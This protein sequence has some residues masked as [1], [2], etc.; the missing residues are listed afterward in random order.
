MERRRDLLMAVLALGT[1]AMDA[2]C[3][4]GVGG[5][6]T[7]V[8]TGNM[9]LLGIGAGDRNGALALRSGF[10]LVGYI[11]GTAAGSRLARRTGGAA[12]VWPRH[13]TLALGF[14]MAVMV[15]FAIWFE[16]ADGRPTGGTQVSLMVL[17]AL[18]MGVQSAAIRE[19]R[20]HDLSTTYLTGT[21]TAMVGDLVQPG[22]SW[23][24]V[25]R[26]LP[27]LLGLIAGAVVGGALVT[28]A[29]RAAPA[30]PL[31]ALAAVIAV[32]PAWFGRAVDGGEL[33]GA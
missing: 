13:V 10:A 7:S 21:L 12:V 30:L 18:A 11:G 4:L 20:V 9:V 2:I 29:P 23:A 8:M 3:F 31:A 15:A 24:T 19:L 16:V 28:E 17:G 22:R 26:S 25:R 1:G 6:F 27:I 14:E 5:A 33:F 32:T